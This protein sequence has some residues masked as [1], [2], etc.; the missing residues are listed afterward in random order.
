MAK[1]RS[2]IMLW[3]IQGVLLLL[4]PDLAAQETLKK[5]QAYTNSI[6]VEF[7]LIPAG[8][9]IMGEAL[10]TECNTCNAALDETPRRNVSITKPFYIGRYE[11]TQQQWLAVMDANPSHFKGDR[12]PVESVSWN[13]VQLFIYAL[14]AREKTTAYRLPTEAEWEYAARAGSVTAYSFGEDASELADY[15]WYV[16]NSNLKTHPIGQLAP[17]PWGLYDMHG[18][19][20]EWCRDWYLADYYG[21]AS[22]KDPTGPATGDGKRVRRGG[23]WGSS[24]R[25]L[26]SSDRDF[27]PPEAAAGNTGFRLVKELQ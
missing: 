20:Y 23:Y 2:V 4:R 16:M 17:N 12:H 24:T 25:I 8:S 6:G 14:N 21:R 11:V 5:E 9:F 15:G 26:R 1:K 10:R 7:L 3:M 27:L 13:N 22:S 18:N 19:V